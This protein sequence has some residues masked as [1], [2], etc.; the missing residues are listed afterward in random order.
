M[1]G[2]NNIWINL[3]IYFSKVLRDFRVDIWGTDKLNVKA[4]FY[5]PKCLQLIK[6]IC[7]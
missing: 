4:I 5:C 3:R 1:F 2:K 6:S 7:N